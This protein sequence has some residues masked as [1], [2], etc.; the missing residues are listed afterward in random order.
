M[1]GALDIGGTHVAAGLVDVECW[2][3][4]PSSRRRRP[5]DAQADASSLVA[6]IAATAADTEAETDTVW[7][8]AIPGPFDYVRGV[9]DFHGVGKFEALSGVALGELLRGAGVATA[10]SLTFVNDAHAFALG[11]LM[12]GAG[13]D[14]RRIIATT[15]GTGIGSAF[16]VAG[17]PVERGAG[18]PP[19]GRLDLLQVHGR[20]LEETVSRS[21]IRTRYEI[22]KR[23]SFNSC[24]T[25]KRGGEPGAMPDIR[26]LAL[27][28]T[29]GDSI[30]VEA[31]RPP[32]VTLGRVLGPRAVAFQADAVVI[33]GAVSNAWDVVGPAIRAGMDEASPRWSD[34]CEL[35]PAKRI[36]DSPLI[37]AAWAAWA[38]QQ[39]PHEGR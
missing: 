21:A 30:A 6:Q 39:T 20:P 2:R 35:V 24:P 31:L 26:D 29:A 1:V 18:V 19:Q 23:A 34:A 11:E 38:T 22:A 14:H 16:M 13:R 8:V 15:L 12:A 7:G 17:I 10:A 32:L 3:V 25:G 27:L 28:A 5:L 36:E 33:G 9:G 4:I 37:G